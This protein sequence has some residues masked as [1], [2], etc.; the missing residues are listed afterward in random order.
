MSLPD[1][2]IPMLDLRAPHAALEEE[3]LESIS[4]VLAAGRFV[5]GESVARFEAELAEL[6]GL[7]HALTCNSG[8]DAIWLALRAS[9]VGPG[10]EVL[11]PGFSFFATASTIARL[12]ARPVF[13]DIDNATLNLDPEDAMRRAESLGRLRAVLTVDLFGRACELGELESYCSEQE[14]PIIEDAAQAIGALNMSGE[15]VGHRALAACFSFYPTKNLGALGDGGG[16]VTRD[17]AL[18][19]KIASLRN[20]GETEPGVFAEIGINSRLDAIQAVA[21]SIKMRHLE[22]WTLS[23]RHL[24]HRY[25]TLFA[26]DGACPSTHKLGSS[27]LPLQTPC[28]DEGS[29]RQT[30]H[31]YV[32]R[33]P[34]GQRSALIEALHNDGI[35]CEVYYPRGLHQQPALAEF[36]PAE[37]LVE[38][39]RAC[40]ESLALPLY[41]ELGLDDLERIVGVVTR[42]LRN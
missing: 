5:L 16:V 3:I 37:A 1:T 24:A 34:A 27:A 14:I 7:P 21:L 11:C 36:A 19:E 35:A 18:A 8:T 9:G 17:L 41:P 38:T 20:H 26:E 32:I 33:V 40:Q 23:R 4:A 25:N 15:Q 12:G 10:D 29:A 30:F 6:C 42:T 22:A 13:A 28:A 31:R 2:K 39:E